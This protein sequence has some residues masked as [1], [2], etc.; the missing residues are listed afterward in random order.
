MVEYCEFFQMAFAKIL[1]F[2]VGSKFFLK[3]P[4]D[5]NN[6]WESQNYYWVLFSVTRFFISRTPYL[7]ILNFLNS[8]TISNGP[9]SINNETYNEIQSLQKSIFRQISPI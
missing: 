1:D 3:L 6:D 4:N 5:I 8:W 2:G 7:N 9:L